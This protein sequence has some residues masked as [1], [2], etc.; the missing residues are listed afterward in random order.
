MRS[1]Y[2]VAWFLLVGVAFGFAPPARPDQMAWILRLLTGQWAGEN[3]LV[4]AHFQ[5]MGI[6]PLAMAALWRKEWKRPGH[7]PAWPFLLGAFA[8][9]CFTLLPYA[10]LR[11][12]PELGPPGVPAWVWGL[13]GLGFVGFAGWGLLAGDIAGW[14]TTART[15]G[16]VW[17][18]AWD[19]TAFAVLFAVESRGRL[20]AR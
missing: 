13:L 8:L 15:D 2:A 17:P 1:A 7:L 4:V 20:T 18:M 9:G 6:W 11:R 16:F 10:A 14:V 12:A 3:P 5:L 19:F